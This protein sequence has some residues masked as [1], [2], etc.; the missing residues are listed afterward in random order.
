MQLQLSK[1]KK[2][3]ALQ[4]LT[5]TSPREVEARVLSSLESILNYKEELNPD[6]SVRGYK[7]VSKPKA[8]ELEKALNVMAFA[9]TPMP[10]EHMEQELLKCMMVMV[11]PSQET[12]EDIAMRIRLIARGLSDYPADIFL[13]AVKSVSHTKT[14][15]PSLSEFRD[16]GE[17]RYQK[18]VKLLDMIQNA[19]KR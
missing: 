14:F 16:A 17:W 12:K 2:A 5:T 15:F 8:D 6:F 7:L 11:K 18:R 3:Q 10:Q 4:S 9:M 19:T 13:Y 1:N